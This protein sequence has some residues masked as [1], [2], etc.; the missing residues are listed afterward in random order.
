MSEYNV[1]LQKPNK[2]FAIGQNDR[3]VRITEYIMNIWRI[4]KWFIDNYGVEPVIING[5]QMPLHRNE[6][7]HVKSMNFVNQNCFV[8]ENYMLSRERVT[9]FTQVCSDPKIIIKPEFV[10]RGKGKR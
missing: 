3:I 10:F 7:H 2:R 9:C 4:R 8:K 5:D 6:S 1:S